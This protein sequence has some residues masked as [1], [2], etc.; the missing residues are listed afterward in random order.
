MTTRMSISPFSISHPNLYK[1]A[2]ALQHSVDSTDETGTVDDLAEVAD[3]EDVTLLQYNLSQS[4]TFTLCVRSTTPTEDHTEQAA[5]VTSTEA[6]H[7]AETTVD[8]D[9]RNV[10]DVVVED[11]V[12]EDDDVEDVED[13]D[14]VHDESDK[15]AK[16]RDVPPMEKTMM[17][18]LGA[19]IAEGSAAG[20]VDRPALDQFGNRYIDSRFIT[21][22]FGPSPFYVIPWTACHSWQA[23]VLLLNAWYRDNDTILDDIYYGRITIKRLGCGPVLTHMHPDIWEQ[24]LE[25]RMC[26]SFYPHSE[27]KTHSEHETIAVPNYEN[28][29]RYTV[30]YF[31]ENS[32][33]EQPCLMADFTQDE[34]VDFEHPDDDMTLPAME[35]IKFVDTPRYREQKE[36]HRAK[37]K[38][39]LGP[40]DRVTHTRLKINSFYLLNVLR[41]IVEYMATAPDEGFSL[42]P[43]EFKYPYADFWHSAIT[44]MI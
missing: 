22:P 33:D 25:H 37:G 3:S 39:T 13:V 2:Q 34:P 1:K 26:V 35:E 14:N 28:Q 15:E 19:A 20:T 8:S 31:Q 44:W 24:V 42:G 6:S 27:Y 41:S 4:S 29:V 30:Y 38:L 7:D 36:N 16:S 32:K 23:V 40:H 43:G 11:E 5:S 18:R 17:D 9:D 12:G 21:V 10:E